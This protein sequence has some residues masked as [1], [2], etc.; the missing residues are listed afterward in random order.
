LALAAVIGRDFDIALLAAVA[1]LDE[2]TL[3][4]LCDTAVAAAVLTEADVPG[5][6]GFAHAL[7]EHTLYDGLSASR[8]A[9]AHR[10]I[11]EALEVLCG[12]DP[13]ERVGELAYHW[14]HATQP[15][16]G[17]K[18][19]AYAQR[20]GDRALAQLAPDEAL[21]WYGD[22]I[23]LL[24]RAPA[25]DLPLRAALL[26]GLGDAQRQT[27]DPAHRE[28]LLTAAHLADR[29]DAVDLLV[30]AALRNNRGWASNVG[31]VDHER[32]EVLTRAL[33]RLGAEDSPERARL[34][35]MLLAERT[36]DP[37]F[38]DRLSVATE[39]VDMARR[40]GDDAALIDA[41]RLSYDAI[42]VSDTLEVRRRW[43]NEACDL[44]DGLGDPTARMWAHTFR[45]L[46]ALESGDLATVRTSVAIFESEAERIG[47]PFYRWQVL[48]L[49]AL[50]R[51]LAGE[52]DAAEQAVTDALTVGTE[53][54][55][56]DA[57]LH[58]GGQ[59][60]G[61]RWQQ[62]RLGEMVPLIEQAVLDNPGLPGSRAVLVWAK[63]YEDP[64][65]DA[66]QHLDTAVADNFPTDVDMFWL[67]AHVRWADVAA[68]V[69]HRSAATVL[70][71]HLLP[72]RE[73]FVSTGGIVHGGV[74]HYLGLLAHVLDRYDEADQW[75]TEAL[76][77]HERMESPFFSAFTQTA[78][79]ALLA[80]RNQPGD[81]QHARALLDAALPVATAGGYGYIERDAR[82]VLERIK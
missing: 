55:Q 13:G 81:T 82:A 53:A 49:R 43:T 72:W 42:T 24:D 69:G 56:P 9:R 30:R 52:L 59:L 16:D 29:C 25:D 76:A 75:F 10:T 40:T 41:I 8:R 61:V 45:D 14:A 79:A 78:W 12:D 39:A 2:D 48:L 5:R 57:I 46:V 71:E 38:D 74:A 32:V 47:Q 21:R 28:T 26:L 63:S 20:A 66:T 19:I 18:A 33:T 62:G 22:A 67:A 54:G 37:A 73:R 23:D 44:A 4:D 34:L 11:A 1:D 3:I 35:A 80:D 64:R 77:L 27:G 58:Y 50:V 6:Y 15:Q 68:R 31:A 60:M 36:W 65:G 7:I 17:A 51:M 70:Y